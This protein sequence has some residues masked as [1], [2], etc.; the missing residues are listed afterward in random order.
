[1]E[2]R[3]D[4]DKIPT[5][6]KTLRFWYYYYKLI[7]TDFVQRMQKCIDIQGFNFKKTQFWQGPSVKN[8]INFKK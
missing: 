2:I 5:L 1:M 4:F 7:K 8:E 6:L 3:L